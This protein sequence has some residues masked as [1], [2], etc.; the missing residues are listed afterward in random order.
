[1]TYSPEE[2]LEAARSIRPYL[3]QLL[4][5]EEAQTMDEQLAELLAQVLQ[6]STS[7]SK[8]ILKLLSSQKPTREWTKKFLQ[9][10]LPP[11]IE[12]A[13]QPTLS[14]NPSSPISGLIKYACPDGD[15]VWYQRQVG[16]P[17][18]T[19]PTHKVTLEK[20]S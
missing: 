20:V 7:A 1:M 8:Q 11:E 16:E 4:N 19:C 3:A 17:I 6:E 15:Y 12:K 2:I 5:S 10:K 18:P 14:P 9:N 13:Y